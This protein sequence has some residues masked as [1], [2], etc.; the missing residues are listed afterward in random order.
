MKK[1]LRGTR[2]LLY[3]AS[4]DRRQE[5]IF[6][7]NSWPDAEKYVISEA[8]WREVFDHSC[9]QFFRWQLGSKIWVDRSHVS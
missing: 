1:I 6:I 3:M 4:C 7:L 5:R 2:V 8:A 9:T